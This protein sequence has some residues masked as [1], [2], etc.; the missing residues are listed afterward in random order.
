MHRREANIVSRCKETNATYQITHLCRVARV[1]QVALVQNAHGGHR[2][3][4]C[5]GLSSALRQQCR[6]CGVA[7]AAGNTVLIR[8]VVTIDGSGVV[9]A[10]ALCLRGGHLNMGGAQVQ[11]NRQWRRGGR[12]RG[13]FAGKTVLVDASPTASCT[14]AAPGQSSAATWQPTAACLRTGGGEGARVVRE[15][16]TS[17]TTSSAGGNQRRI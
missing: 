17:D 1:L 9:G 8:V 7:R 3:R 5:R 11:R 14:R 10:C 12:L 4:T 15:V 16:C 2:G 6:H 13:A